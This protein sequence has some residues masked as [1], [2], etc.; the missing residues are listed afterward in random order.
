MVSLFL[1][2]GLFC[3]NKMLDIAYMKKMVITLGCTILLGLGIRYMG[4]LEENK[5]L[6]HKVNY[7]KEQNKIDDELYIR[8]KKQNDECINAWQERNNTVSVLVESVL[9]L[10]KRSDSLSMF[11]ANSN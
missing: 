2:G 1:R 4:L 7:L 6:R 3:L 8:Y 11:V 10:K 5:D 9:R